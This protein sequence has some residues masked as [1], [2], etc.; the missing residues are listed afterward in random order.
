MQTKIFIVGRNPNVSQGEIP[1]AVNDPSKKVSGNHCRITF[2]GNYFYIEDL[3]STNGTFVDGL[4]INSRTQISAANR[5]TLGESYL[6][7]LNHP[8]I[9]AALSNNSSGKEEP[10]QE[11][12]GQFQVSADL[13]VGNVMKEGFNIGMRNF[14]SIAVSYL[15]W[16]LT[17]WIPYINVGTTIA[18]MTLP[19][20]LASNK[21]MSP[22]EIFDSKY[23][24][25][26]GEFFLLIGLI[27]I[28]FVVTLQFMVVPGLIVL[29]A[30]SQAPL[31]LIDRK[32]NFTECLT[33]SNRITYGNKFTI[34]WINILMLLILLVGYLVFFGLGALGLGEGIAISA[35]VFIILLIYYLFW[36]AFSLGVQASIYKVL[37]KKI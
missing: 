37:S 20:G 29:I 23:R 16:I 9:Q 6:F 22:V 5:I 33:V 10:L 26:F 28:G 18:I 12:V 19:L 35:I 3:I 36:I 31:I 15:L 1:V 13:D 11:D 4:R 8:V 34:F 7:S 24:R 27:L 30:W 14:G 32:L 17:I 2:D 25:Q 21:N